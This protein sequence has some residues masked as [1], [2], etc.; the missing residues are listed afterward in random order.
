MKIAFNFPLRQRKLLDVLE[1]KSLDALIVRKK[2]NISYLTGARGE[3]SLLIVSHFG[4]S[5][6]TDAR[7][8]EEYSK[9]ARNTS[10]VATGIKNPS[11]RVDGILKKNRAERVGFESDNLT[12]SEFTALKKS[13]G[14]IRLVPV[15][16]IV[17]SLRK[18][19]DSYE[20]ECI[21]NAC[22]YGCC[23]MNYGLRNLSRFST[24]TFVKQKI[25][26]YLLKKG[27]EP[28]GFEIIVA[29]GVNSSMPHAV[30]TDK[31]IK[32][33]KIV[34]ID[35]GARDCGYN[36]DLTR[37]VFLGRIKRKYSRV[38]N[39]VFDAQKKAIDSIK[40][41]VKASFIDAISRTYIKDKGFGRHFVHS[42][43]HGI[44]LEIH[45]EP[46]LSG[47]SSAVLEQG[48]TVTVE[49]GIYI[50][51]WGGIR[52]EDVVLVTKNGCEVLTGG[53][54]KILCR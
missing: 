17:E 45:E 24:E 16:G 6:I 33:G 50:P 21:R 9:A 22:R 28:A 4:S 46:L 38:Y 8:T 51:R 41:G 19:K 52:I 47:K 23:A 37:T 36:S 40:P 3:E 54:G 26:A 42:L 18:V 12:Y 31:K 44:G 49:P 27:I 32:K 14:N 1:A 11:Q 48:M 25:E 39:V 2:E 30:A 29:S 7:Y 34:V 35:L 10:V 20:I 13:T 5:I 53:C 15:K 43:G